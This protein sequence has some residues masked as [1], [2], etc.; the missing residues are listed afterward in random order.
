M[1]AVS[2]DLILLAP[3]LSEPARAGR[4]CGL[5]VVE[6]IFADRND[7]DKGNLV[8]RSHPQAM[9]HGPDASLRHV[10]AMV[11]GRALVPIHGKRN[12]FVRIC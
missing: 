5:P 9:V 10:L 2:V 7:T 3:A 4:E 6:E 1:R 8:P 11:Q 12:R